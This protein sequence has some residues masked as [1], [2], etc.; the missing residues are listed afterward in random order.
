MQRGQDCALPRFLRLL[1]VETRP[2]D[3]FR[4]KVFLVCR[5][6]RCRAHQWKWFDR[7][8]LHLRGGALRAEISSAD[9]VIDRVNDPF[10]GLLPISARQAGIWAYAAVVSAVPAIPA[11]LVD[12]TDCFFRRQ[13]VHVSPPQLGRECARAAR[14]FLRLPTVAP[15]FGPKRIAP[16]A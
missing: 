1:R 8:S 11:V 12:V 16:S 6:R 15:P 2:G 4:C 7:T 9:A 13:E 10:D 3:K 5:T 14:A